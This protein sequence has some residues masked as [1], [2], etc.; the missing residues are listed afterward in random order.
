MQFETFSEFIAMG[1]HGYYVWLAY[2]LSVAILVLNVV[3]PVMN[4]KRIYQDIARNQRREEQQHA[5]S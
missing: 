1:K 3:L 5:S 2:G 4:R